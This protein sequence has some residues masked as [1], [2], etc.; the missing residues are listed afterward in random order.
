ME[1]GSK[2]GKSEEIRNAK[3]NFFRNFLKIL[4][5]IV[6]NIEIRWNSKIIT[7]ISLDCVDFC[8]CPDK[9]ESRSV[10]FIR[11]IGLYKQYGSSEW[12][13]P[14][15]WKWSKIERTKEYG[16]WV[17]NLGPETK[18][19]G[20]YEDVCAFYCLLWHTSAPTYKINYINMQ[21]A[22]RGSSCYNL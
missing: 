20:V 10:A 18:E 12:K 4:N 11:N 15:I 7:S 19:N 16:R 21:Q 2:I 8:K 13:S 3:Y 14:R 5:V 1:N 9:T 6:M 17:S 22:H